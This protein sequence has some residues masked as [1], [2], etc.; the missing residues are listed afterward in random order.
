MCARACAHIWSCQKSATRTLMEYKKGGAVMK[1]ADVS[2]LVAGFVLMFLGGLVIF[3]RARRK[4]KI[5]R[6]NENMN[7]G[8][9]IA[10]GQDLASA[11][12]KLGEIGICYRGGIDGFTVPEYFWVSSD[13]IYEKARALIT[14]VTYFADSGS[15]EKNVHKICFDLVL[16]LARQARKT[17]GMVMAI[18]YKMH[19]EVRGNK[20]FDKFFERLSSADEHLQKYGR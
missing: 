9:C 3:F 11:V 10:R 7:T 1:W 20:L 15:D 19:V 8:L 17:P 13:Y 4:D 16:F 12:L 2:A 18:I 6:L 5:R 14:I